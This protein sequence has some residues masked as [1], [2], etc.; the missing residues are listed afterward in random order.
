M[1][2]IP[3]WAEH[4]ARAILRAGKQPVVYTQ[5]VNDPEITPPS[6]VRLPTL[7][8]LSDITPMGTW[9]CQPS[10]HPTYLQWNCEHHCG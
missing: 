7:R 5:Q 6:D 9:P 3:E 10:C 2:Y 4:A 1:T 8:G